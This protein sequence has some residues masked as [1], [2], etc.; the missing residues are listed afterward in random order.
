MVNSMKILSFGEIL[1]DVYPD[2]KYIGGAPLN[3]A[4]HLSKHGEEVHM[5]STVGEDDLGTEAIRL[6]NGWG[7][8]SRFVSVLKNKKTGSCS[9]TLDKASVP[10]YSLMR[11][12]AYDF[13][14]SDS[15]PNG[16]DALY[17]GTLALRGEYNFN[18]LKSLLK[19]CDFSEVF[20]DVNIRPPFYSEEVL[21]FSAENATVLKI[22]LEELPIVAEALDISLLQGCYSDFAKNLAAEF[23]NLKCIIITLGG[24]GAYVL[25]CVS[26]T[27][28]TCEAERVTVVS[29][30][31]AGDSFGAA[32]MHGYLHKNDLAVCLKYAV[33]V[34][35]FVVSKA[36]AIP[37]YDLS[38][39]T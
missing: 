11:D 38:D 31:G 24:D 17:F 29:T 34:A 12:V 1:W 7:V 9:V 37:D 5:L 25:D 27:E 19:K 14:P 3:F 35:G 8:S 10:T 21:Y 30:V 22:S 32:F 23:T 33:M 2:N 4:A 26:N 36:E 16:F 6:L 20:V 18:S 39:F 13:I 15:V 28:L